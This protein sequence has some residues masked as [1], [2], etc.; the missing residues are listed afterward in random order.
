MKCNI[1][2]LPWT[3]LLIE[4]IEGKRLAPQFILH[5]E[6]LQKQLDVAVRTLHDRGI[7]W[8]D[9]KWRNILLRGEQT[10]EVPFQQETKKLCVIDF[11]NAK[12]K[13]E[14]EDIS[15]LRE[16]QALRDA[17]NAHVQA[18]IQFGRLQ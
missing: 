14:G 8:N 17:D 18:M 11:S 6:D 5:E 1:G 3:G 9:V 15:H 13:P 10:G 7:A 12:L 2:Q 4:Y 16:W